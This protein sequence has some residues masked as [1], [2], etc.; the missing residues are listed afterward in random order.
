ML[1]KDLILALP[2]MTDS[3][4][5]VRL[6]PAV[7]M[8]MYENWHTFGN[9]SWPFS[10]CIYISFWAIYQSKRKISMNKY[11]LTDLE[12]SIIVLVISTTEKT[13]T[14]HC[15]KQSSD[16]HQAVIRQSSGSPQA[17][18]RQSYDSYHSH[19]IVIGHY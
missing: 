11:L 14:G 6:N 12:R 8:Y 5:S 19:E 7:Y 15:I 9:L 3:V 1:Y 13:H 18:I 2:F 10:D 16:S 17:V 4:R